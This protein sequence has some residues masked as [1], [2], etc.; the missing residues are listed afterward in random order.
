MMC[1]PVLLRFGTDAQKQRFLP[2]IYQGDE[3]WC[4]GYSEPGAGSDLA[5]LRT[6]AVRKGDRYVVDGQKIWTT[7]AHFA[8]WIFCLVRTSRESERRQEGISFLLIDMRTPG[9]TV[10]PL[11][12]M[13]GGHEVN[14]VFLDGV[15]VPVE[16]RVHDEGAGWT[17][18]K[19]LLG[20]E[21]MNT[22]RIGT[23]RRE[24]E[25][26]KAY[27]A[28][29]TRDG[30]PLMQDTRFRDRLARLEIEL[31]ALS[32]TNLRFLDALRAGRAPGAEVSM[33]KI[34]GTEIQQALT[35]L[36]MEAAGPLGVRAAGRGQRSG[37]RHR[38]ARAALLQLPQD[39]DLRR[40]QRDPAQ[41][42]RQA[43]ARAV[44][45]DVDDDERLL[46]ESVQRLFADDVRRSTRAGASSPRP[47]GWSRAAWTSFA[48]LGLLGLG[49]DPA[50]GG[51]GGGATI[52]QGVMEAI[53]DALVRRAVPVDGRP[54][55]PPHRARRARRRAKAPIVARH[56]R[57][58]ARRRGRDDRARRRDTTRCASRRACDPTATRSA[59]TARSA[60]CSTRRS[61]T[62]SIVSARSAGAD[63]DPDGVDLF[64]IAPSAP[65]VRLASYRT[66]DGV[67]RRGRHRSTAC[68]SARTTASVR[69]ARPARCSTRRSTMRRR[70]SAP[71]RSAR[72]ARPTPPRSST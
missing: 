57:G 32:I 15:E 20:H 27:A 63:D 60:S 7:H 25:K 66:L 28:T 5:S 3:F 40:V 55:R 54:R 29:R 64:V 19:Y 12:L 10:R 65:G 71:K 59:S 33:L 36:M 34:R 52:M 72:S 2:R 48:E 51:F 70:S 9:I 22:A 44:N 21:R 26:L 31:M 13:D 17:V 11:A 18:A 56:R 24:L 58:P 50:H 47:S 8:D 38:R 4:Q 46:A 1:G 43:G 16:N 53:G 23:S 67:H 14:E 41:H 68:A 49:I 37:R 62:G 42:H 45:F 39:D 35:E 69:R 30:R 6:A 61:P